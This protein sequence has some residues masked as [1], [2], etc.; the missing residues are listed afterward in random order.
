MRRIAAITLMLLVL[1][2]AASASETAWRLHMVVDSGSGMN[3]GSGFYPGVYPTSSDLF[4]SRDQSYDFIPDTAGTTA[5]ALGPISGQSGCFRTNVQAPTSPTKTWDMYLAASY[6]A[7]YL[8][9]RLRAFTIP[10][11]PESLPPSQYQGR[12]VG[13]YIVMLDNKGV[14]GAP[15]NGTRWDLPIPTAVST[16]PFWI[17]PVNLPVI[18]MSAPS[19]TALFSEGYKLQF[20]QEFVPEPSAILALGA[21]LCGLTSIALRRRRT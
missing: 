7:T 20:V 15:A 3:G 21:G 5:L 11:H 17:S 4:D 9:L 2:T 16:E 1:A 18:K 12:N 19:A 10:T 8:Q 14:E 13:Y 6:N